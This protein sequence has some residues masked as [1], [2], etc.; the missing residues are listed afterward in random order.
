MRM[1]DSLCC[2]VE[3]Q[4][5]KAIAIK[6]FLKRFATSSISWKNWQVLEM[7]TGKIKKTNSL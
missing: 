2:T 6:I 5:R 1:A 3:T 7:L 4:H